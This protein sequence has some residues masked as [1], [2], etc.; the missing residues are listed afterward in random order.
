MKSKNKDTKIIT[1]YRI[2]ESDGSG[3][4]GDDDD[5]QIEKENNVFKLNNCRH[6][7]FIVSHHIIV[8]VQNLTNEFSLSEKNLIFPNNLIFLW[9]N[10]LG[11]TP[12]GQ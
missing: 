12:I 2:K 1:T 11:S 3:G 4:G 10:K 7:Q 9:L 8:R 5:N 6:N